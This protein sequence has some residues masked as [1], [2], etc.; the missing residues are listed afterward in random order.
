MASS[1]PNASQPRC[2][3]CGRFCFEVYRWAGP[4]YT[5]FRSCVYCGIRPPRCAHE[6]GSVLG[7]TTPS[8]HEVPDTKYHRYWCERHA[9][10]E[11]VPLPYVEDSD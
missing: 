5:T 6:D 8:T 11:A 7:C 9:P 2:R 3:N 10:D 1:A 4:S